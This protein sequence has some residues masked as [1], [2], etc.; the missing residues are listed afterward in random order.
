MDNKKTY[1]IPS[2]RIRDLLYEKSFLN[3]FTGAGIQ[4]AEEED[5]GQL[6]D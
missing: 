5:W 6:D 3:S 4:D 1:L 2:L